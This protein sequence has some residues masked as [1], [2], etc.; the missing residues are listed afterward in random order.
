MR[1]LLPISASDN[2][3]VAKGEWK[4]HSIT[5]K[6]IGGSNQSLKRAEQRGFKVH[7]DREQY[8]CLCGVDIER[9]V[10][11]Y[12]SLTMSV[13]EIGAVCAKHVMEITFSDAVLKQM[14]KII[15]DPSS[16]IT[17]NSVKRFIKPSKLNNFKSII[18]KEMY[19]SSYKNLNSR[20]GK[21]LSDEQLKL[22]VNLNKT[23]LE[24]FKKGVI[25]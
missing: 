2:W 22:R 17:S 9:S 16:R 3:E 23:I 13:A 10:I 25:N 14:E 11:V 12:N 4:F 5:S 6:M 18:G 8:K 24:L 1:H 15:K 20:E 19:L 21:Y 7:S